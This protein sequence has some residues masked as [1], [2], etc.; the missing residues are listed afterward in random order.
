VH[1]GNLHHARR[2]ELVAGGV[3]GFGDAV[4]AGQQDVAGWS[5]RKPRW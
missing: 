2:L 5:C 4:G 1:F 3:V